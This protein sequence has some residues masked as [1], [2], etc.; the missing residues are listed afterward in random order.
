MANILTPS[1]RSWSNL[2][3]QSRPTLVVGNGFSINIWSDF[4]YGG[5][6]SVANLSAQ[7]AGVF[8]ALST[9]NF[10]TVLEAALHV[11][12]ITDALGTAGASRRIDHFYDEVRE[13]LFDAVRKV[14]VAWSSVPEASL[15][16]IATAFYRHDQ[17]FTTNYDLLPYWATMS[18]APGV[19]LVD[20]F[21]SAGAT[22]DPFNAAPYSGRT[23]I[24]YLHG[25]LH[26][27][28]N[29][30][31]GASGKWVRQPQ[32]L[33]RLRTLYAGAPRRL[34]LFV[35]EG[36][37]HEKLRTIRRSDY[38]SHC[39]Q[40]L[41]DDEEDT[42][43]FGSSLASVDSH[44]STAIEAGRRRRIAVGLR[45][46]RDHEILE[47]KAHINSIFRRHHL[48]FFDASTHPLGDSA[49]SCSP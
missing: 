11:R 31:T 18:A 37:T 4:A 3:G 40:E 21:W 12:T 44:V 47:R 17:V 24:Y 30:Q 7:S 36:S 41:H 42:V 29:Q 38:L 39:L 20:L 19:D 34:P 48:T 14:H 2:A 13:A 33:L 46:G 10:E 8:T 5:L 45:S 25:G 16:S 22:F 6:F 49:L 43:I 23:P 26:L 1:L 32:G 15:K 9:Q 35:S 27:W 28:Q